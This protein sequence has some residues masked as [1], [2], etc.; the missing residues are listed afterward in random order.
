[1]VIEHITYCY[2]K[3]KLYDNMVVCSTSKMAA[4]EE[5]VFMLVKHITDSTKIMREN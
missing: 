3:Q 5:S 4:I 2:D 1:M